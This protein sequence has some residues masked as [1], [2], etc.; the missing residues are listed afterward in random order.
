MSTHESHKDKEAYEDTRRTFDDLP[1]EDK[2]VF[3]IE[4]TASTL[5]RGLQQAGHALAEEVDRAFSGERRKK[6]EAS[7]ADAS[8]AA[9]PPTGERRAPRSADSEDDSTT[10]SDDG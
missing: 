10:P 2:A 6:R 3:L 8:G 9:E 1:L 5:A 7:T 4:A